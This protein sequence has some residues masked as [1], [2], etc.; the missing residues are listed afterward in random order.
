M[1]ITKLTTIGFAICVWVS[2]AVNAEALT[3]TYAY[4]SAGTG[5]DIVS[6]TLAENLAAK[7]IASIQRQGGR[8]L[9]VTLKEVAENKLDITAAPFFLH[10]LMS[11][12]LG[13]YS[14]LGKKRGSEFAANVRLLYP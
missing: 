2:F 12:G 9:T 4:S 1:K 7:G 10:F 5:G 8:V 11:K 3:L 6:T 13:P 14:G